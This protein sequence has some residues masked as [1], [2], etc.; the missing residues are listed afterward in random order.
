MD[1]ICDYKD[2]FFFCYLLIMLFYGM[3]DI[4]VDDFVWELYEGDVWMFDFEI[5]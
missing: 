4:L 5:G 3:Y 1:F 2:E